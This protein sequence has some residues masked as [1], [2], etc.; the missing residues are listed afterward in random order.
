MP[1]VTK[2][3]PAD[4]DDLP[5]KKG[6]WHRVFRFFYVMSGMVW[7]AQVFRYLPVGSSRR[8]IETATKDDESGSHY[9]PPPGIPEADLTEEQRD[10][11]VRRMKSEDAIR[12]AHGDQ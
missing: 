11:A 9:H 12:R 7:F 4:K 1:G 8:A 6:F 3:G 10:A 5:R 2:V